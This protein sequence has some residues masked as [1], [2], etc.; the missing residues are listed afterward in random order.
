MA[1]A[2]INKE[3]VTT[4]RRLGD[5]MVESTVTISPAVVDWS[6]LEAHC[7]V[8][9]DGGFCEAPWD[10][11]DGYEHE[12]IPYRKLEHARETRLRPTGRE[13]PKFKASNQSLARGYCHRG[14]YRES[15]LVVLTKPNAMFDYYRSYG[16]SKQ[17]AAEMC[18][19]DNQRILD[20]LTTWYER[21]WEWWWVKCE[22]EDFE[23]SV[24]GI[25]SYEYAEGECKQDMIGEVSY[26][27]KEAGYTIT[28]QPE[29]VKPKLLNYKERNSRRLKLD[30]W[31]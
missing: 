24:G 22:Y 5:W 11:C 28:G 10:N 8:E 14:G 26:Q 1:L 18:A 19:Q 31:K 27:M 29:P 4:T 15:G 21:G 13:R 3:S 20:Q 23:A 6:E 17:V 25:D 7:K 30:C 16:M 12:W 2:L 9:S